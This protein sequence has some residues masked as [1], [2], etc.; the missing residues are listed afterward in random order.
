MLHR[1]HTCAARLLVGVTALQPINK[2]STRVK[3][4]QL[5]LPID[6]GRG[7]YVI[8]RVKVDAKALGWCLDI[9]IT[10]HG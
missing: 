6:Q 9:W 4:L 2:T 5:R 7:D 8:L 10:L 3:Y 1:K